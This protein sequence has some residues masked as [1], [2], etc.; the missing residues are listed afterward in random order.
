[1]KLFDQIFKTTT[2][3]KIKNEFDFLVKDFGFKLQTAKQVD[4]FRADYFLVYRNDNSEK[5]VE[6][7]ADESWFHSEIRR[8]IKGNPTDYNDSKN[9]IS[10]EDLA[11][12]ESENN[13]DHFDYYAGGQL[14]LK[15]VLEN[16]S[17][18]FK[19]NREF[20]TTDF[21]LDTKKIQKLKDQE[22]KMKFGEI[23]DRDA[24]TFF[25][26]IKEVAKQY[27]QDLEYNLTLDSDLTSPFDNNSLT[28]KLI[29]EKENS[30]I[31]ISQKDWRDDYFIYEVFKDDKKVFEIDMSKIGID[32][33][34]ELTINK[35]KANV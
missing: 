30:K 28:D 31:E 27:L 7:C 19:R 26:R 24:P 17:K 8:L 6:I 21:W 4:N 5:Q 9:C 33:A 14:G 35:V 20:L 16:T 32:R 18:L 29:F 13:Y 3:D 25:S 22:F 1:M 11:R 12:W 34:V 10:F 2:L 15:G 23:P